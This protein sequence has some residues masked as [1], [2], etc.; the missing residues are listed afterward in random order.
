M[1]PLNISRHSWKDTPFSSALLRD[2]LDKNPFLDNYYDF[3]PDDGGLKNALN[4]RANREGVPRESLVNALYDQY[5]RME[6][7]FFVNPENDYVQKN[8]EALRNEETYTITT[9]HQPMF[10]G[11]PLFLF[12]KIAGAI[13]QAHHLQKLHPEKKIVPVLWMAT[14]DHDF[15][16][17]SKVK[18]FGKD[19]QWN[20]EHKGEPVGT[21][22]PTKGMETLNELAP[23]LEDTRNGK[24]IL[25]L[26]KR[27]YDRCG[28][29]ACAT[30]YWL[31]RLFRTE[32]LVIL[33]SMDQELKN[34]IT[35]IA[36]KDIFD[37]AFYPLVEESR[38]NLNQYYS[39]PVNPREV[40][41]FLFD[42]GKRKRIIRNGDQF[43]LDDGNK[44][45]TEEELRKL[46]KDAPEKFSPNVVTRPLYQEKILPNLSYVGGPSEIAYWMEL[47]SS[48]DEADLFFPLLTPRSSAIWI[49]KGLGKKLNKLQVPPSFVLNS[50]DEA[51]DE[52][53]QK[54]EN[55]EQVDHEINTV[56]ASFEA[57]KSIAG[58][59]PPE[60]QKAILDYAVPASKHLEKFKKD[61][62]RANKERNETEISQIRKVLDK[63][64]PNGTPQERVDNFIPYYLTHGVNFF[65][66][67]LD[68]MEP[69]GG[70]VLIFFE[71]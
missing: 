11:G 18:I 37:K 42:E 50:E 19:W 67:L 59:Q 53:L 6:P 41:F 12:Y 66:R 22:D 52:F 17:V 32:G 36:E 45:F 70:E 54:K 48:F 44:S 51:I 57:L 62:N 25:D 14:E 29:F 35:E 26:F 40:N 71:E 47:K 13:N 27:A 5:K 16:E 24:F 64:Y 21:L 61:L 34:H 2:Y 56:E 9:G 43:E 39:S 69:Y 65:S 46:L 4:A 60:I 63:L 49:G 68:Y 31:N 20:E 7:D 15:E 33:D 55:N 28:S 1:N 30:R 23:K 58:E 10:L 38:K 8:V 3:Y